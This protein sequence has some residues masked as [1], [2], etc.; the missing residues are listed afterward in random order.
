MPATALEKCHILFL[1]ALLLACRET[2]H[3]D[4]AFVIPGSE[5][6]AEDRWQSLGTKSSGSRMRQ[7]WLLTWENT[8]HH[9]RP[10][11][12]HLKMGIIIQLCGLF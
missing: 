12:L 10:Q 5:R 3:S 6:S 2:L 9:S 11:F 4:L 7:I 1:F 8:F